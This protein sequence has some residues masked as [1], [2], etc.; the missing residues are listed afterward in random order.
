MDW[1]IDIEW[2][3]PYNIQIEIKILIQNKNAEWLRLRPSIRVKKLIYKSHSFKQQIFRRIF[4]KT[5]ESVDF[6]QNCWFHGIWKKFFRKIF[7]NFLVI[8]FKYT[9]CT[10][11]ISNDFVT[12]FMRAAMF[13]RHW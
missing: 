12:P 8:F 9:V 1:L 11:Y 6:L 2:N 10:I 13:L 5:W 7:S 4:S 3:G